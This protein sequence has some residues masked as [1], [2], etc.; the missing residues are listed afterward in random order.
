[1]NQMRSP[2]IQLNVS[3]QA[4]LGYLQEYLSLAAPEAKALRVA[5]HPG[6]GEQGTLDVLELLL[7]GG[8]GGGLLAA[9]RVLPEFLRSRRSSLSITATVKGQP[10]TITAINIDEVMPI[11]ERLLDD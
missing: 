5:G 4:Q 9:I 11:L 3:D 10:V 1:M 6:V 8:G 7:A 2:S